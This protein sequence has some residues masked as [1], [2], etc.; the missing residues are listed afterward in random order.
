MLILIFPH[1]LSLSLVFPPVFFWFPLLIYIRV[2]DFR[3]SFY[4]P[5][6]Y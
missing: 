2:S 3:F 1:Y 4:S 5:P 6:L